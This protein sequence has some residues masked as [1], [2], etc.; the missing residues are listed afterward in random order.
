M[1]KASIPQF[2]IMSKEEVWRLASSHQTSH[3]IRRA[4]IRHWLTLDENDRAAAGLQRNELSSR[5]RRFDLD[6]PA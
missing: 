6:N 3:S 2:G 1:F 5:M 4:A